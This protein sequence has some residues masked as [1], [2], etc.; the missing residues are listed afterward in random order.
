MA[1]LRK[2][3]IHKLKEVTVR[4]CDDD[5]RRIESQANLNTQHTV[6]MLID[7][8]YK[9]NMS[10]EASVV[11]YAN[12]YR[13]E[14]T[15]RETKYREKEIYDNTPRTHTHTHTHT[16]KRSLRERLFRKKKK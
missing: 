10:L 12:A 9:V 13:T 3:E 8:V 11:S 6:Q 7:E 16:P 14:I 15:Q 2:K 1:T 5:I 4:E